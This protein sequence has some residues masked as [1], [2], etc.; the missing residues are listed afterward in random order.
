[1]NF[2]EK[3]N[4][5]FEM[6]GFLKII[7]GEEIIDLFFLNNKYLNKKFNVNEEEEIGN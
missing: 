5:F 7:K 2:Q 4:N 6:F 3:C 1:M